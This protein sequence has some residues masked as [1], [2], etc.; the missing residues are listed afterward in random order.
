MSTEPKINDQFWF[1]MSYDMVKDS[2]K[3]IKESAGKL[4]ALLLWAFGIY[5]GSAVFTVEFKNIN[6]IGILLILC[7]PYLFLLI[8]YWYAHVAQFPTTVKFDYRSPARIQ[9][10]YISGYNKSK[11]SLD[12]SKWLTFIGFLTLAT[13][14]MLAFVLK[15]QPQDK[16][17][18]NANLNKPTNTLLVTGYFPP[19][20]EIT[21][22]LISYFKKD[23]TKTS[24]GA[25]LNSETGTFYQAFPVDTAARKLSIEIGWTDDNYEHKIAKN[26]TKSNK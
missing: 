5:T 1:D 16:I 18:L 13:S 12:I 14:L 6:S 11:K 15:N 4:E 23:S 8:G 25:F 9:A 7:L 20:K 3:R 17:Y 24:S 2:V 10:A 26:I 19:K 21:F 22:H